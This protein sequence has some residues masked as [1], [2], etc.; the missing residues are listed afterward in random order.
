[1]FSDFPFFWKSSYRF[2][3]DLAFWAWVFSV[4][5][6]SLKALC[7][8]LDEMAPLLSEATEA[9]GGG[10]VAALHELYW[11]RQRERS[12]T[13][14]WAGGW[15]QRR[16]KETVL[17][18]IIRKIT[19]A[20]VKHLSI[21]IVGGSQSGKNG[22]AHQEAREAMLSAGL[23]SFYC[24]T[25]ICLKDPRIEIIQIISIFK[26]IFEFVGKVNGSLARGVHFK[27]V[28]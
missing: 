19:G 16:C 8:P 27:E 17:F 6:T 4:L 15:R 21:S 22:S 5:R 23:L 12:T 18:F 7:L 25:F 10:G 20:V 28:K 24:R 26:G 3:V 9:R 1:M 13:E 14:A 2:E 11:N